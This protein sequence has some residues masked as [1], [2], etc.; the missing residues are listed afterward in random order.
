MR[1][2]NAYFGLLVAAGLGIAGPAM[3]FDGNTALTASTSPEVALQQGLELYRK[4]EKADAFEVLNF[5]AEKGDPIAQWKA[6]QMLA[7]GDGIKRDDFKA[8]EM[9]SDLADAHAE[10]SPG[11]PSSRFVSKAFVALGRYYQSGIPNTDVKADLGRA[12]QIYGHAALIYG[13][14]DAQYN[15]AR[16][17]YEGQGGDR[18]PVRAVKWAKQAAD[19]CV[20]DAQALLGHILFEGDDGIERE[21]VRGLTYLLVA[22]ARARPD[23]TWIS[24]FQEEAVSVAT[25]Q[26]RHDAAE[27]AAQW[28][29][30][31][32]GG[33][34]SA[35]Q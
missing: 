9:F 34:A 18:D 32:G 17:Y 33:F 7:D 27:L 26:E 15:L 28:L 1:I 13:D 25:A 14:G 12:R 8:F 35:A 5:A 11:E 22:G 6:G 10:D 24:D 3:A 20:V 23:Q 30:K 31:C 16:M 29:G 4:G 19:K 21:P 2:C